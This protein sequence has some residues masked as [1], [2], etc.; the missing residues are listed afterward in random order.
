MVSAVGIA[1]IA[2]GSVLVAAA[3]VYMAWPLLRSLWSSKTMNASPKDNEKRR[4]PGTELP[5]LLTP[6]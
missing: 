6:A 1:L 3:A 5:P 2:T 4:S